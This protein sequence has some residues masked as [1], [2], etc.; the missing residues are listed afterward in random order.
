MDRQ[1]QASAS[2]G[3]KLPSL[4]EL[5]LKIY[6]Q[7][8]AIFS[9]QTPVRTR[10][11]WATFLLLFVWFGYYLHRAMINQVL[12]AFRS[13][14]LFSKP[15]ALTEDSKT[16][17]Q[18]AVDE[19]VQGFPEGHKRITA[20]PKTGWKYEV[21]MKRLEKLAKFETD[22][23]ADG[24]YSTRNFDVNS[25]VVAAC[26]EGSSR[27]LFCNLLFFF[28]HASSIQID[29]EVISMC[30]RMLGGKGKC[31]GVTTM[32][33]L[34]NHLLVVVAYKRFMRYYRGV[35]EPEI[36]LADS[37]HPSF[38]KACEMMDVKPV[39]I[40]T[41]PKTMT[42]DPAKV[43]SKLN[44]NTILVVCSAPNSYTGMMDPIE[45]L[46]DIC[47]NQG[48]Y[49]HV[50]A[51][52]GGFILPFLEQS[53]TNEI[54]SP[55]HFGV[56]GISSISLDLS[57]YG[58]APTNIGAIIYRDQRVQKSM[59]W[60]TSAWS[61]YLYVCPTFLGSKCCNFI[62]AGW[63]ALMR[64]GL[65]G[66]TENAKLILDSTKSFVEKAS[67]SGAIKI[68]GEPKLG[69]VTFKP[70]SEAFDWV[71]LGSYLEKN[72]WNLEPQMGLGALQVLIHKNNAH[73]LKELVQLIKKGADELSKAQ[74]KEVNGRWIALAELAHTRQKN[75]G[76]ADE[77][78]REFN[79]KFYTL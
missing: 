79:H 73:K 10:V 3:P 37:A 60:G 18:K 23:K 40:K 1:G 41:D 8:S 19:I 22:K 55:V 52:L 57:T 67:S 75:P 2:Q 53:G 62:A 7:L 26:E 42:I 45:D 17:L 39:I 35:T 61:G 63:S 76:L 78:A 77:M 5:G 68:I 56:E 11:L 36:V 65:K 49:L 50:D 71:Q 33:N 15:P 32:G 20:L 38:F 9:E 74:K 24:K 21:V 43:K 70:S 34:E 29:N 46:A 13:T 58:G 48:V 64:Q 14:A 54:T 47:N 25:D 12:S 44:S 31:T 59:Y 16:Q 28:L 51:S 4:P 69:L 6:L 27:F 72:G 30:L 66:F